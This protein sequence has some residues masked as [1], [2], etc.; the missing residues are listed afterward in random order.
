MLALAC[1]SDANPTW[2]VA[3]TDDRP[4]ATNHTENL[5]KNGV[6]PDLFKSSSASV[7][8]NPCSLMRAGI[9]MTKLMRDA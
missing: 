3:G 8:K 7:K 2:F 4:K 6:H 9:P 1:I 5:E